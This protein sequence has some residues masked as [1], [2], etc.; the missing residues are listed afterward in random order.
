MGEGLRSA[1]VVTLHKQPGDRVSLDDVLCEVETDKA[2]YPIEASFAGTFKVW[3]VR[4]DDTVEIGQEI[5]LVAGDTPAAAAAPAPVPPAHQSLQQLQKP[6]ASAPGVPAGRPVE[7]ALSAAI[8]RRLAA[9]IAANVQLAARWAALRAARETA[10]RAQLDYSPSLMVAWCVTRAME[11][12][13]AFRRIVTRDGAILQL[14]DFDLGFAVALEGDRLAT[15]VIARSNRLAWPE[16]VAAYAR[17]LADARAGRIADVQSPINITSL[18]A[19]GIETATP[20]VVP[21]SIGTLF[22]GKAHEQMINDEGVIHPAEVVTLSLTFD[23]KVI[24]GAGAAAF[25]HEVKAQM[26]SFR[27]PG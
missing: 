18:G 25:L 27:L 11:R 1:R 20:I 6:A 26:E 10:K 17:A 13:A 5:A 21:P 16:L 4:I 2:V 7:P 8:T 3:K 23:H 19:F 22:I 15:A 12:H 14:E 9:V 24:N